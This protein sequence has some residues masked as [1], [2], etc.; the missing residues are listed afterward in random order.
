[1]NISKISD[2]TAL[3]GKISIGVIVSQ[4]APLDQLEH[5][6]SAVANLSHNTEVVIVANGV[7]AAGGKQLMKVV[8][9]ISDAT[10][11]F[12][13]PEVELDTA[14]LIVM[15]NAIGD[16]VLLVEL[17][18]LDFNHWRALAEAAAAGAE[19]AMAEPRQVKQ[20]GVYGFAR[21][22]FY[23]LIHIL[24]NLPVLLNPP[25]T[26]LY[27]RAAAQYILN[28]R[29]GHMLLRSRSIGASFPVT[30]IERGRPLKI[31]QERSFRSA[32]GKALRMLSI[33]SAAPVRVAVLVACAAALLNIFYSV[34]AISSYYLKESI[35]PGW[36]ALS[37][38]ISGMF[39]IFSVLFVLLG[40]YLVSIDRSMNR[41]LRYNVVREIRSKKSRSRSLRNVVGVVSNHT[42]H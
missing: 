9:T 42:S 7:S 1:M 11:L 5:V 36:A 2:S 10:L 8:D 20:S 24:T 26:R 4:N 39:F 3:A 35:A 19:V 21:Q 12:V 13:D 32:A 28:L 22:Q 6:E 23:K 15:D 25:R 18:D 31:L 38:Q 33:S 34:Y 17:G 16:W 40:E 14:E 27:S 37:L 30:F 29:E 41:R